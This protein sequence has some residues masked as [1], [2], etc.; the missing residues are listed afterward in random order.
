MVPKVGWAMDDAEARSPVNEACG[1]LILSS[2]FD[3]IFDLLFL[4]TRGIHSLYTIDFRDIK[5]DEKRC[6][7]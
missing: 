2:G 3:N 5:S 4:P 7:F 6:E 1:V